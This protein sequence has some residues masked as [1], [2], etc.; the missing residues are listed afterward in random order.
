M[1]GGLS[2]STTTYQT[3]TSTGADIYS[4][5]VGAFWSAT[6]RFSFGPA[7]SCS[8]TK[9]DNTGTRESESASVQANYMVSE[10]VHIGGSLGLQWSQNSRASSNSSASLT[11]GLNASYIINEL[12]SC[13]A[14]VQHVNVP[15]PSQQNYIV[16]DLSMGAT[17]TRQLKIGSISGGFNHS[18]SSY[19]SVGPVLADLSDEKYS[20][21]FLSYQRGFLNDRLGFNSS[22]NYALNRG[23]TDWEQVLVSVGLSVQF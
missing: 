18:I 14:S 11:G 10:K 8:T 4:A 15:A 7:F 23:T 1:S 17:L 2:A 12:W 16:N 9:S 6:E 3:S 21:V 13:G 5:N 19:E 22:I 20:S